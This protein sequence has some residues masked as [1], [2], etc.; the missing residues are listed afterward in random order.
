MVPDAGTHPDWSVSNATAAVHPEPVTPMPPGTAGTVVSLARAPLSGDPVASP[1]TRA[2]A[3][4]DVARNTSAL[5]CAPPAPMVWLAASTL[6]GPAQ[7]PNPGQEKAAPSIVMR[8][9]DFHPAAVSSAASRLVP[10]PSPVAP[11][12]LTPVLLE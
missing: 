6:S 12:Q 5:P 3:A 4:V 1:G 7:P 2:K 11:A 10:A 8:W 9:P